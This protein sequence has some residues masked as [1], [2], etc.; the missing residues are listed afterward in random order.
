M[1][2]NI[3]VADDCYEIRGRIKK[4]LNFVPNANIVGEAVDGEEAERLVAH[5]QP[6][7]LV[8]DILMPKRSGIDVLRSVKHRYPHIKVF[9]LSNV[10]D[11]SMVREVRAAGADFVFDKSTDFELLVKFVSLYGELI[12]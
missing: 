2:M 4:F 6:D 1:N 12:S 8:L 7:L 9:V 5:Y 3:V 11:R 10:S